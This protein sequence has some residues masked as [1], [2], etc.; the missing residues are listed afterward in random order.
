MFGSFNFTPLSEIAFSSS[1]HFVIKNVSFR[2]LNDGENSDSLISLFLTTGHWKV[3]GEKLN[4]SN[5]GSIM[6]KNQQ[7]F[8]PSIHNPFNLSW[9]IV[10]WKESWIGE[11]FQLNSALSNGNFYLKKYDQATLGLWFIAL[12]DKK[13]CALVKHILSL[14]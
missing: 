14:F 4:R 13:T 7:F 10:Y 2:L 1:H 12:H 3:R 11:D 8:N 9:W 6:K 5:K